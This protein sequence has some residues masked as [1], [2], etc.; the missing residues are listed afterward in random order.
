MNGYFANSTHT[1][2]LNF[3]DVYFNYKESELDFVFGEMNWE[4]DN[5]NIKILYLK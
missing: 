1:A 3:K 4:V 5:H 2:D